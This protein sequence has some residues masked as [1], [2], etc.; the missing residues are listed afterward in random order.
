MGLLT[1]ANFAVVARDAIRTFD[2]NR[3]RRLRR[4]EEGIAVGT[5]VRAII[6]E[7]ADDSIGK[8]GSFEPVNIRTLTRRARSRLTKVAELHDLFPSCFARC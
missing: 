4:V 3:L 6:G 1:V 2:A 5:P 8:P 7:L